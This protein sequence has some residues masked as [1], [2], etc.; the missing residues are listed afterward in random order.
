MPAAGTK[1]RGGGEEGE[2][3]GAVEEK[4]T[5]FVAITGRAL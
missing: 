2:V 1:P 3:L 4:G 5:V